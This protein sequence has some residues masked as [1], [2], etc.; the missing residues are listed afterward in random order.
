MVQSQFGSVW[1]AALIITLL[2]H[3]EMHKGE[4]G[5]YMCDRAQAYEDAANFVSSEH[6][7]N[8]V[9]SKQ[10]QRKLQ[11]LTS[12]KY[13]RQKEQTVDLLYREGVTAIEE[14]FL[15]SLSQCAEDAKPSSEASVVPKPTNLVL[16]TGDM[17]PL[18]ETLVAVQAPSRCKS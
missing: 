5:K 14:S 12:A 4:Q 6:S 16:D 8:S 17:A 15:I 18:V 9:T 13:R 3:L 2:Q 10:V 1:S 11:H 7:Q